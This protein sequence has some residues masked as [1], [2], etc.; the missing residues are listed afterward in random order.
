LGTS[1]LVYYDDETI[2][3]QKSAKKHNIMSFFNTLLFGYML[4]IHTNMVIQYTIDMFHC[5]MCTN[6]RYSHVDVITMG[7]LSTPNY[8]SVM[9]LH[10]THVV[11]V[12]FGYWSSNFLVRESTNYE[13]MRGMRFYVRLNDALEEI[14]D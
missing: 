9:S 8:T 1:K 6:F 4:C 14:Y 3:I 10:H 11:R 12:E 2:F 7:L 5:I 13:C